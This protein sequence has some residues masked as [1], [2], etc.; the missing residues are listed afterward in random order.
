VTLGRPA[1]TEEQ[2][3]ASSPVL[4]AGEGRENGLRPT[5]GSVW[6]LFGGVGLPARPPG[7]AAVR[8]L[9]RLG[10]RDEGGT[11]GPTSNTGRTSEC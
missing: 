8:R 10:V 4:A 2:N 3:P 5:R 9:R 1:G 7:G 11:A 6:G